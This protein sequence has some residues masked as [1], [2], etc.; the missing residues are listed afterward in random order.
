MTPQNRDG[1]KFNTARGF[2]EHINQL[3][4]IYVVNVHLNEEDVLQ[5][6]NVIKKSGRVLMCKILNVGLIMCS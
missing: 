6:P 5:F 4:I 2:Q 1:T 3:L